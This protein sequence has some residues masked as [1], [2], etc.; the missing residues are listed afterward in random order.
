MNIF[1]RRLCLSRSL[2][3]VCRFYCLKFESIQMEDDES[4]NEKKQKKIGETICLRR[5]LNAFE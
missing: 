2:I 3:L 4:E 5:S 1:C